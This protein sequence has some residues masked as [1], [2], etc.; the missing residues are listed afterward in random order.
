MQAQFHRGYPAADSAFKYRLKTD[1]AGDLESASPDGALSVVDY[2]SLL[3]AKILELP[4]IRL[5]LEVENSIE[6]GSPPWLLCRAVSK[7]LY[8]LVTFLSQD[9]LPRTLKIT[10]KTNC[11][12]L[13]LPS[14]VERCFWPLRILPSHIH[15]DVEGLK[16]QGKVALD[17]ILQQRSGAARHIANPVLQLAQSEKAAASL[18]YNGF[19]TARDELPHFARDLIRNACRLKRSEGIW[20]PKHDTDVRYELALVNVIFAFLSATSDPH[21]KERCRRALDVAQGIATEA[22]GKVSNR[23]ADQLEHICRNVDWS[24]ERAGRFE[25]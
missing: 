6:D 13:S 7:F 9:N 16:E 12:A 25:A 10:A 22:E 20:D 3:P 18:D 23:P 15:L 21:W 5:E 8:A 2:A 17:R 14:L 11:K 24:P 19:G 1:I 4:V